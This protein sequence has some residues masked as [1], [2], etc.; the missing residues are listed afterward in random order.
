MPDWVIRASDPL[1]GVTLLACGAV[2]WS[3]RPRSWVG[4]L[5][6]AAAVCWFLGSLLAVAVFLHRGPMVHL[7]ISYPTGRVRRPVAIAT[8]IIAYVAALFEAVAG[9]A[10]ITLGLALLVAVAALDVYVRTSGRARKAGGPALAAA[11]TFAGVLALSSANVILDWGADRAVLFTYNLAVCAVAVALTTDLLWGRWSEAT[12]ADL[13]TQL[14]GRGDTS[15]LRGELQRALGDPTLTLG[16]WLPEQRRY[17]DDDGLPLDLRDDPR[18]VTAIEESGQP[19][20][21]LVHDPSVL[22]DNK[23]VDGVTAALRLAVVNSVMRAQAQARVSELAA[24]RRR[25]VEAADDQRRALSAELA[26]GPQRQL[27]EIASLIRSAE[28]GIGESCRPDL[29][30]ALSE[31]RGAQHELH[32]LVQGI[33]PSALESGGLA[34]ALPALLTR[35]PIAVDLQVTQRRMPPAIEAAIYFVCA[36]GLANIAK[37]ADAQCASVD[38]WLADGVVV[39][40]VQD[41]GI[42]GAEPAG[43]GLRGL[44]D[45]VAALGGHLSVGDEAGGGTRLVARIPLAVGS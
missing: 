1:V 33:R 31:V 6:V 10:W 9:N 8:V 26:R 25:V 32:E 45:R 22:D 15:G 28:V 39:I 5:M 30:I 16:Y 23:L 12:V 19:L 21:V 2:A 4:L 29:A 17:V 35:A 42:G 3:R 24:S 11:L 44:A 13:V 38:V 20:A 43:S 40:S 34:A 27:T 14:G 18:A 41:D 36:E 7:H 37:H